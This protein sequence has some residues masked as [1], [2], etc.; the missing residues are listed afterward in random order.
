MAN[1]GQRRIAGALSIVC[2]L[3][4]GCAQVNVTPSS[5]SEAST[6]THD[7]NG[8]SSTEGAATSAGK[9]AT[10]VTVT[11]TRKPAKTVTVTKGAERPV[12]KSTIVRPKVGPLAGDIIE[13]TSNRSAAF[14]VTSYEAVT[15]ETQ[16]VSS[17][18]PAWLTPGRVRDDDNT[19]F[20]VD[21]IQLVIGVRKARFDDKK[22]LIANRARLWRRGIWD[23][24]YE[25]VTSKG[26]VLSGTKDGY[27]F[28]EVFETSGK[29]EFYGA[30]M[31]PASRKSEM[32]PVIEVFFDN[33]KSGHV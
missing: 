21:D 18:V 26:C 25:K 13:K 11:R 17:A 2:L 1:R 29:S 10:T 20:H 31:Y 14:P 15:N 7:N 5:T 28:Y 16:I 19:E 23:V 22:G 30:W 12:D 6:K 4:A 24:T 33:F 8:Q 32:D 9:P 27:I 3:L